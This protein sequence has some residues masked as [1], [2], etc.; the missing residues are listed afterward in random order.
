MTKKTILAAAAALSSVL[1]ANPASADQ[2][3]FLGE[4]ATFAFG[5][6]P[7]GW[8]PLDGAMLAIST[9]TALFDLL[10]TTYGGDGTTTFAL[11]RVKPIFT[12]SPGQPQLLQCIALSGVFPT[13]N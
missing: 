11:P 13:Q 2:T 9:N 3:P 10:G 5:F 12:L 8:A 1:A 4:I 6:C 7:K